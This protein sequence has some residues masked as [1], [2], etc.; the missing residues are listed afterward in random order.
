MTDS[1]IDVLLG[2]NLGDGLSDYKNNTYDK[3][4]LA[5]DIIRTIFVILIFAIILG[6]IIFVY[7]NQDALVSIGLAIT[8]NMNTVGNMATTADNFISKIDNEIIKNN[9]LNRTSIIVKNLEGI[10]EQFKNFNGTIAM[11]YVKQITSDINKI[12]NAVP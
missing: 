4:K 8:D 6:V 2:D 11:N 5:F 10:T 3:V 9:L 1:S 12:A 7:V